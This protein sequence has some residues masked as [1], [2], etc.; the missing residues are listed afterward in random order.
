MTQKITELIAKWQQKIKGNRVEEAKAGG[1][2]NRGRGGEASRG[3]TGGG[4]RGS[5]ADYRVLQADGARGG[6]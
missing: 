6:G 3:A 1:R 5:A 4:G 2:R